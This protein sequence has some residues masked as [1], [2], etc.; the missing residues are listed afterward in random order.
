MNIN[1]LHF[2]NKTRLRDALVF[3]LVTLLIS[4]LVQITVYAFMA[5][6]FKKVIISLLIIGQFYLAAFLHFPVRNKGLRRVLYAVFFTF[7]YFVFRE[8]M[9]VFTPASVG[10]IYNLELIVVMVFLL[11][12]FSRGIRMYHHLQEQLILLNTWTQKKILFKTPQ[13][14]SINLGRE[15]ELKIHPNELVYIRT[16]TAGDHTKIFGI[17]LRQPKGITARLSEHE[18]TA[19]PNFEQILL[20][21]R[22]YPQFK[23][24]H[25]S[26]VINTIYPFDAKDGILKIEG[27][28]F[29]VNKALSGRSIA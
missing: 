10:R 5:F 20:V 18:T 6:S 24:I 17:K 16:K 23:R 26:T 4:L 7:N 21:L 8:F 15:G 29:A 19:Y 14:L 13:E 12:L 28:R 22:H 25:Q 3:F 2:L 11:S 1:W 9:M 27:R